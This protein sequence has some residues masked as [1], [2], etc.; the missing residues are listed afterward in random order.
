VQAEEEVSVVNLSKGNQRLL[1]QEL[2]RVK[3]LQHLDVVEDLPQGV[4]ARS[5]LKD[6]R[7][8]EQAQKV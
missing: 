7:S 3:Q 2:H 4:R 1:L 5:S 8:Q 6:L